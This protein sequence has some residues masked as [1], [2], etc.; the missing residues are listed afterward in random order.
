[1]SPKTT[2]ATTRPSRGQM[3]G[4]RSIQFG[5]SSKRVL[6]R[7]RPERTK[8]SIAVLLGVASVALEA[9]GPRILGRATDLIFAGLFG[10][11]L[12][13]GITQAEAVEAARAAGDTR[14]ADVLAAMV[15]LVPGHGVDFEAVGGVLMFV[16]AVYAASSLLSWLQGYLLNDVVQATVLR[17]RAD[18]EDKLHR[19][20]LS[21]FDR[22]PRGELISRVTNDIDNLAQ[23]LGQT[24]GQLLTSL[25]TA[26]S[27][28][29]M[30]VY[31][32][33]T[34]AL[35]AVIAIPAGLWLTKVVMKRSQPLFVDQWQ[36]TGALTAQVEEAFTGHELTKVFGRRHA[37]ESAFAEEN[38]ALF[39]AS[40]GAQF[41]SSLLMPV[42]TF[43][44]TLSYVAIAVMGGL[45]VASGAMSL[46]EVQAF[47][48]YS[49]QLTFPLTQAASIVNRLQS[50]VAS[51]ERVFELL[52][53]DEEPADRTGVALPA[54]RHGRV[55]FEDVAFRYEAE[56]PL[57]TDLSFVADPGH[58]V[59]IVGPTGAGKT[60]LVNLVMRFYDLD[61]GRIT[62]DGVDIAQVPRAALRGQVGM[63]LQDTW[64][65]E[66]TIRDNI[67]YGRP[68][69]TE[70][71]L[72]E[73]AQATFV[74][75]FV[76]SLPDGYD[77]VVADAGDNLS[78]G[79]RQLS[80]IARAFLA[81]PA[82][83]ILDEATSSVDTRTEA[84]LQHAMAALRTDRTSFVI[85]HRLSTIRDADAILVM[86]GGRIVEQG[87]HR[88]LLARD[89]AYAALHRTQLAARADA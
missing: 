88:A 43:L 14:V 28:V 2:P 18:V 39:R 82:L 68:D 79:E 51:A 85:A 64:L 19:L 9:A 5:P 76:H 8:L 67:A 1:M 70:D 83:L 69:A 36:H 32:S 26:I 55:A 21:Y 81:D 52:D 78:A 45:R 53:A 3:T 75:R 54:V 29:A 71:E 46:G 57:I 42:M 12:E 87:S 74:D 60:T 35:V 65:F 22:H 17:M 23:S 13:V 86:E 59:A 72:L 20:P 77:T 4:E 7:L 25:L 73:A 41:I 11:Q 33:A 49:G 58:T 40:F 56:T 6:A 50:G 44:G 62:L 47:I 24:L 80:T 15:D 31:L 38:E 61:A 89:G 34:M 37:A 30:M 84:L 63:V 16:M 27:V 48:S 66:G 10:R